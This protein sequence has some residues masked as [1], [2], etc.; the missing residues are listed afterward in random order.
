MRSDA[1]NARERNRREKF[2]RFT[3][4][5]ALLFLI[6]TVVFCVGMAISGLFSWKLLAIG[7][8]VLLLM[9]VLILPPLRFRRFKQSR[10]MIAFIVS[11]VMIA[12]YSLG[13]FY[14][15]GAL[16]F[17][18]TITNKTEAESYYVVVRD[19]DEFSGIKDIAGE[20][21]VAYRSGS[22]YTEAE[23]KLRNSVECSVIN[24]DDINT[25]V[26]GLL[27]GDYNVLF[28]SS[29]NYTAVSAQRKDAFDDYTKILEV[30]RVNTAKESFAKNVKVTSQ[31]F[32][33]MI[34][35][36]DVDGSIDTESRSDVN[37]VATVNPTTKQV[38]LTSI[39]RDYYVKLPG[40]GDG[41]YDKLTHTG[42]YGADETVAAVEA[43]LGIDINYYIKVNYST[44]V[45]VVDAIG[46]I[47][48]YSDYEFTTN[49]QDWYYFEQGDI[50]LDGHEALA[51]ARERKAFED[52]DFQRN[53]NQQKVLAAIIK[54]MT[55]STALLTRYTDILAA[56][57]ENLEM[58][59][60]ADEIKALVRM[61]TSDM[62]SWDIQ[63]QSIIGEQD[64]LPCYALG[65]QYASVVRRDKERRRS[66]GPHLR[67]HGQDLRGGH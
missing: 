48:V 63:S 16:D 33:V 31:P 2:W 54:K 44:V 3:R 61:Q 36:L 9:L 11:I 64:L 45:R 26:D 17:I 30:I 20:Q 57:K 66:K 40:M 7:A 58:N 8:G 29:S 34:T 19:D 24:S 28:M 14:L 51:F 27:N 50:H 67:T 49:G 56:V 46:G 35:G 18:G 22:G 37:I 4:G 32:N 1:R 55:S 65:G 62:A 42:L 12:V 15:V 10:R 13:G 47:D 5:W 59:M 23:A 21:V 25:M 60:T 39:P 38:L 52:G 53:K 43:L 41:A 6:L